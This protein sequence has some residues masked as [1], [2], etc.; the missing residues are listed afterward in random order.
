VDLYD[1]GFGATTIDVIDQ[2]ARDE[3]VRQ[4][5]EGGADPAR[6]LEY[7]LTVHFT[8]PDELPVDPALDGEGQDI[9]DRGGEQ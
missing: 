9:R 7:S 8:T 1:I 4:L 2:T 5:V 3:V 6:A